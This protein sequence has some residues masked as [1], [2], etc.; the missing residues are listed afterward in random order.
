MVINVEESSSPHGIEHSNHSNIRDIHGNNPHFSSLILW[1]SENK[2]YLC[3][4]DYETF[5]TQN[6]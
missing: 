6:S 3:N 4:Q 1:R 5:V 2:L